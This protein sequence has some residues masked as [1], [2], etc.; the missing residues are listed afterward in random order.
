MGPCELGRAMTT[1]Q[2]EAAAAAAPLWLARR[3]ATTSQTVA[4]YFTRLQVRSRIQEESQLETKREQKVTD[5]SVA[6][7]LS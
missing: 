5:F 1:R 7:A 4:E 2:K 3:S 6:Y